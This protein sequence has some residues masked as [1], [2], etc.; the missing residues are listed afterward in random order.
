[1][2]IKLYNTLTGS[3]DIFEPLNRGEVKMYNCGPTVYSRQHIGNLSMFVF[4]DVLR[5]TLRYSGF[6]VNQ[7][8]NITDFGH[9]S[10]DN[11][12]DPDQGED[13]MTRGLREEGLE[14]NLENMRKLAEKYANIF[15]EDLKKL[16]I[17]TEDVR[18]P[19]ASDYISDQ[20]ELIRILS[21]KGFTYETDHGLYFDTS[22][23]PEYGKLGNINLSGLEEGA[24]IKSEGRKN[25]TDF[26]LWKKDEKTGWQSPWGKGF[27]GWHIECSAMIIKLLGEQIDIH[28]GGIEHIPVHHNNEIAQSESATGKSP[29]SRFW[30]HRAH[31]KIDGVKISKSEGKVFYLTD[32]EKNGLHP[33]SFRYWLLTSHYKTPSNFTLEAIRSAQTTLDKIVA[34]FSDLPNSHQSDSEVLEK[35][36]SF[37]S[38]DLNTP[39]A[40]TL[41]QEARSK[42]VIK[43]M[44]EI[45]GLNIENLAHEIR[46]NIPAEIEKLKSERDEARRNKDWAKSDSLRDQIENMGFIVEDRHSST[47]VRKTLTLLLK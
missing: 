46:S 41:L 42:T 31:L 4:T 11:H 28:T 3:K 13:K 44:D 2:K 7:V 36:E 20:I 18:F 32:L 43:K 22:K 10:G 23:F 19:F 38:D 35:F 16:N 14:P 25:P 47:L 17:Q 30:L 8:I 33:M 29:F 9:L 40:L 34:V 1:M 15:F 27:P 6:K 12:G 24:R 39:L 45:F 37:I 5:R 26:I 21:E